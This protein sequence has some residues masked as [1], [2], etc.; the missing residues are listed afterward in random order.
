MIFTKTKVQEKIY[1][2]IDI[3][4]KEQNISKLRKSFD[5]AVIDDLE[6]QNARILSRSGFSITEVGDIENLR[7]VEA[8]P[9]I[10]CDIHDVGSSFGGDKEGAFVI[11]EIRNAYPDKYIIA[12]T[13]KPTDFSYQEYIRKA[14]IS[15]P[16]AS[17][18]EQWVEKLDESIKIISD[19]ISRWKRLRKQIMDSGT[20]I[21]EVF[22]LE[23]A[24]IKSIIEKDQSILQESNE[25]IE[26][27]D[28]TKEII[29]IF[30]K[31]ALIEIISQAGK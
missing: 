20:E 19:P 6:F 15:M 13:T 28:T 31:T 14:D 17:S 1:K 5:I 4:K 3:P 10:I 9:I 21:Y 12:Y 22:Q 18:I 7:T 30:A 27:S 8:Y 2:L 11:S 23:Q 26:L 24:Y 25:K 29:S 16:K